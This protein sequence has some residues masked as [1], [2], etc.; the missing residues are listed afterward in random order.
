M[1][2][3][4]LN[5]VVDKLLA[6]AIKRYKDAGREITK[7]LEDAMYFGILGAIEI[8]GVEAAEKWI[9]TANLLP[10]SNIMKTVWSGY[11]TPVEI[12]V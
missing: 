8:H 11:A 6:E 2:K 12:S 4:K 9:R 10:S 5:K 7:A 3:K 1:E